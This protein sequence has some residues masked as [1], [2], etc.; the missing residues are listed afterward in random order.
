MSPVSKLWPFPLYFEPILGEIRGFLRQ[1][2]PLEFRAHLYVFGIRR[3]KGMGID[4]ELINP[5][6]FVF[7]CHPNHHPLS[8]IRD[9]S[10]TECPIDLKPGC[11]FK[12]VRW[13]ETYLKKII[14]LGHEGTLR[15]PF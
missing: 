3:S 5:R 15:G 13:L 6:I 1:R 2:F 10:G 8:E 14:S 4:R 9:C 11:K 7:L 12:F